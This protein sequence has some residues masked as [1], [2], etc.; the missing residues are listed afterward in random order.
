MLLFALIAIA[1][2]VADSRLQ[3]LG[4]VRQ[5]VNTVLY[6]IQ[7]AALLPR[8]ALNAVSDYFSSL[9][10]MQQEIK[11]MQNERITTPRPCSNP[12]F[13]LPKMRTCAN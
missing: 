11:E 9:T 2:L 8:D 6:P 7:R 3:A 5:V 13:W 12:T 1:L 10:S 4:A